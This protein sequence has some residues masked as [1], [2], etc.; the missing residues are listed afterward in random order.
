[1]RFP[2]DDI[3]AV[4][5]MSIL[6]L[7]YVPAVAVTTMGSISKAAGSIG[8]VHLETYCPPSM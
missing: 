1:M 4:A 7:R 5:G 3:I 8:Y 6:A 2:R